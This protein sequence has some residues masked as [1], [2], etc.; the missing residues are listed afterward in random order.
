M[1]INI[2][3]D[4]PAGAGKSTIAKKVA[5]ELSFI[6]V[7]TGGMYR[8]IALYMLRNGID[9]KEETAVSAACP[10]IQVMIAYED[11]EQRVLLNGEDVSL[12]IRKE[13]VGN[14]ASAVAVYAAVR[15]KL[16]ELQKMLAQTQNVVMDGRDIGSAVLPHAQVKI[17]LTA[18]VHTRAGRRFKELEEKGETA[19]IH[20]IEKDI[21]ERDYQDMHRAISPLCQAEDAVLVDSSDMGIDEVVAA[22][23]RI[24]KEKCC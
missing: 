17:Y 18:S 9:V 11:G 10:E 20:I 15:S 22:I 2:A 7:D 4:G 24:Y 14:A 13:E 23:M 12:L 3:I 5:K 19:D 1:S 8:A 6:Y 21:E 16:T